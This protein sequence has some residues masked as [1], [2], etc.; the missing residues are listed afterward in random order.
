MRARLPAS[1]S[2]PTAAT[3]ATRAG[4]QPAPPPA[5]FWDPGG[6]GEM[7]SLCGRDRNRE[8]EP[9]TMLRAPGVFRHPARDPRLRDP[10]SLFEARGGRVPHQLAQAR[11]H[12]REQL[13]DSPRAAL[14]SLSSLGPRGARLA[15]GSGPLLPAWLTHVGK[16]RTFVPSAAPKRQAVPLTDGWRR[17]RDSEERSTDGR[18]VDGRGLSEH[19]HGTPLY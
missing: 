4:A 19:V 2:S 6:A 12:A 11:A 1:S 3:A 13:G 10:R 9:E 15:P 17:R 16:G 14:V 18:T 8:S 7:R 5:L